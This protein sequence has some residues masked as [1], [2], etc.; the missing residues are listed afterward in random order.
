MFEQYFN[1]LNLESIRDNFVIIYELLDEMMDFGYPQVSDHQVLQEYI[2][3][4]ERH[5]YTNDIVSVP[6][7]LTQTVSW[8]KK[9]IVYSKNEIFLDFMEYFHLLMDSSGNVLNSEIEGTIFV[10]SFLSG[11]PELRM[12]LNSKIFRDP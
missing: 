4:Q 1:D 6:N 5:A 12:G 8:R 10:R 11:I 3:I 7:R 9:G 2:M